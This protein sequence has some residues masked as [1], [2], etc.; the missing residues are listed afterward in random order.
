MVSQ[1]E[2]AEGKWGVDLVFTII[3]PSFHRQSSWNDNIEPGDCPSAAVTFRN[4]F[5]VTI[6][7][8][9]AAAF[10]EDFSLSCRPFSSARSRLILSSSRRSSSVSSPSCSSLWRMG[11]S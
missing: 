9:R 4:E 3:P 1:S 6:S 10:E 5:D 8:S 7:T 2:N 11:A